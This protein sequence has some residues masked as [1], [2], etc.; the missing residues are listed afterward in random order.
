M[1]PCEEPCGIRCVHDDR[2]DAKM[3]QTDATI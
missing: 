1:V 3:Y 2:M